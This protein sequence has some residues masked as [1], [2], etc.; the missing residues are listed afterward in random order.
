M[1]KIFN[2]I[3]LSVIISATFLGGCRDTEEYQRL[4]KAGTLYVESLDTLLKFAGDIK[5]DT[6]SE[7]LLQ[8][9]RI[10]NRNQDYYEKRT[11]ADIE[12]LKILEDLRRHNRLLARYFVLLDELA[13]SDA[14]ERAQ[15]EIGGIVGNINKIGNKLRESD[16][17][18]DRETSIIG[19]IG[20][21]IISSQIEGALR[22]ELE[23]RAET[24]NKEL[25]T[26][27]VL[28][29]VLGDSINNELKITAES[30]QTRLIIRPYIQEEPIVKEDDWIT[31]RKKVLT[32]QKTAWELANASDA[33]R[34]FRK[35]FLEVI[36][37]DFNQARFDYYLSEI[38]AFLTF[39][40]SIKTE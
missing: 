35:I 4:S 7:Q 24:I 5:I 30:I 10:L 40:E 26:Q 31:T 34:N 39:V 28:L 11:N 16:L 8:D 25:E 33:A 17:I 27:E 37:E 23:A 32:S 2:R 9:D 22:E 15:Q 29:D 14:P 19:A 6:T 12:R 13:S 21:L 36:N 18:E 1:K 38:E 3:I 20:N